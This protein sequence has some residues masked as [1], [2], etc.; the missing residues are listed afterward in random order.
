MMRGFRL[1]GAVV[2][3][4]LLGGGLFLALIGLLTLAGRVRI[5]LYEGF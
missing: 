3:G 5:F 2:Q 4:V 1:A